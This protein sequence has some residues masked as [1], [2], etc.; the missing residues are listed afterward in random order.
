MLKIIKFTIK[1]KQSDVILFINSG[2]KAIFIWIKSNTKLVHT[3]K[4]ITIHSPG[5]V[6]LIGTSHLSTGEQQWYF[7][8]VPIL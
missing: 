6:I 2:V 1:E 3:D 8:G 5:T 4:P 7:P